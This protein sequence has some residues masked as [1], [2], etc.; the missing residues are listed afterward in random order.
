MKCL[1]IACQNAVRTKSCIHQPIRVAIFVSA[2]GFAVIQLVAIG[3]CR[4]EPTS[5]LGQRLQ[6]GR[7]SGRS[8]RL[9]PGLQSRDEI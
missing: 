9:T 7:A 3:P 6:R 2:K 8:V 1:R 4:F 5:I